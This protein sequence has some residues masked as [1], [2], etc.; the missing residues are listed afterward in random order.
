MRIKL[1]KVVR[2][3]VVIVVP[4]VALGLLGWNVYVKAL[5]KPNHAEHNLLHNGN[6]EAY[7]EQGNPRDWSIDANKTIV[8]SL[9]RDKG[10]GGGTALGLHVTAYKKGS[11]DLKGASVQLK[12]EKSY[13][14]KGYYQSDTAFSLLVRFFYKD[15]TSSLKHIRSYPSSQEWATASVAFETDD[16]TDRAQVLY[17]MTGTGTMR[18]DRAYLERRDEGIAVPQE[19]GSTLPNL[20]RNGALND[21]EDNNPTGWTPFSSGDNKSDFSYVQQDGA[22]FLRTTVTAYNDGEAKWDHTPI[23]TEYGKYTQFSVDYRSDVPVS[24]IAEYALDDRKRTFVT[25]A[26]LPPA[27]IW[28]RVTAHTE[29]PPRA[30]EV[31]VHVVLTRD[32]TL[33]SD[34]YDVRDLTKQDIRHFNRPLLSMTFDG[35]WASCYTTAARIM[36]QLK[37]K[38]T[39]YINPNAIGRPDFLDHVQLSKLKN[40][41]HQLASQGYEYVELTTLNVR[42]LDRQ[43]RLGKEYLTRDYQLSSIDFAPPNGRYDPEVQEHA[44]DYYRSVRTTDEGINTKQNIDTYNL[45]TLYIDKNTTLERFQAALDEAKQKA[46]WLIL[47]YPRVRD[48]HPHRTTVNP[49]AFAEQLE[50]IRKSGITVKTVEGALDEVW[51][52]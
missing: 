34:N 29:A 27:D 39:F 4:L 50:L 12:S 17:R 42:Q 5:N 16:R 24:I 40:E 20:I 44:R 33:D 25:L 45:K 36:E 26:P 19:L 48:N 31:T 43:L 32:G 22:S 10:Y 1:G 11:L 15:G 49:L 52:Q 2:N 28:T 3:P 37:Y 47:V 38:G 23:P 13:F 46:G 30:V 51:A 8:Y 9:S 18:L 41:G 6:F 21:Q 35:S 14:Y 7:D